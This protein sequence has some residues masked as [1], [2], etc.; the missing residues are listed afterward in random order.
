MMFVCLKMT[1]A[2]KTMQKSH[3]CK[4]KHKHFE[5]KEN[6]NDD[7]DS[8]NDDNNSATLTSMMATATTTATMNGEDDDVTMITKSASPCHHQPRP[9]HSSTPKTLKPAAGLAHH[10]TFV[11][12]PTRDCYQRSLTFA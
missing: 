10:S 6:N 8:D 7:N 12:K 4:M 3:E 11:C 1:N 9:P 2:S 5:P